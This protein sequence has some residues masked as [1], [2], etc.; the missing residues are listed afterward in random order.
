M[1][2]RALVFTRQQCV[3]ACMNVCVFNKPCNALDCLLCVFSEMEWK[4]SV[5]ASLGLQWPT[6]TSGHFFP[7]KT[8]MKTRT[9]TAVSTGFITTN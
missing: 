7:W 5:L 8:R 2:V 6:I 4:N 9:T 1:C 3:D